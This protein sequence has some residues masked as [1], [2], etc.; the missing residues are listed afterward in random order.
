MEV[1][2]KSQVLYNFLI[3]KRQMHLMYDS[4]CDLELIEP[5]LKKRL[6]YCLKINLFSLKNLYDIYNGHEGPSLQ[7][8]YDIISSHFYRCE[9]CQKRKGYICGKCK[10]PVKIF[11]FELKSTYGCKHCRKLYHRYC[12]NGT[13]CD[14]TV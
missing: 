2:K 8:E 3:L 13:T 10:N 7:R 11:A 9:R 12:L 6:N 1:V 5:L 14:C 4:I